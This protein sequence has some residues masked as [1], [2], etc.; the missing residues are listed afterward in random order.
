M[1][2]FP[3]HQR[4]AEL[5][6]RNQ[7][8]GLN[9]SELLEFNLCMKKFVTQMWKMAYLENMSLMASMTND[10]DWQ[11]EVCKEIDEFKR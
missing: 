2:I 8:K 5:W 10:V 1:N 7:N 11:F 6:V 9:D 3:V 4:I